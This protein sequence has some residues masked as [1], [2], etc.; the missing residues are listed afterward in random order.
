MVISDN[1][2]PLE[3]GLGEVE[4]VEHLERGGMNRAG[5]RIL[6]DFAVRLQQEER[7]PVM[8]QIESNR[9]A[10]RPRS[11]DQYPVCF[12]HLAIPLLLTRRVSSAGRL[13]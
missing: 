5:A 7:Y 6:E 9:E 10:D 2:A 4:P 13:V 12:R 11:D 8:G 3:E 1:I